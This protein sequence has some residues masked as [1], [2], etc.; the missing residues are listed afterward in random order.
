MLQCLADTVFFNGRGHII[1]HS[2]QRPVGIA[3]GHSDS[4]FPDDGDIVASVSESHGFFTLQ[5]LPGHDSPKPLPL[6][7]IPGR[8]VGKVRIPAS[9]TALGQLGQNDFLFFLSDDR[10]QLEHFLS[11]DGEKTLGLGGDWDGCD[12][13]PKGVTGIESLPD[14]RDFLRERGW[15]E[16]LLDDIFSRNLSRVMGGTQ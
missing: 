7:G 16:E 4:G 3:H 14:F 6:V 13:F 11:L 10:C 5:S 8:N 2:L 15:P 12:A 1:G 9:R